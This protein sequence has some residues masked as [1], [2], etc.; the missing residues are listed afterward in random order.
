MKHLHHVFWAYDEVD[1]KGA[2]LA[3][4]EITVIDSQTEHEALENAKKTVIRKNYL[5]RQVRE[6]SSCPGQEES[7]ATQRY[8][9]ALVGKFM[10]DGH[11]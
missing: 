2:L 6:C 4:V 5:F 10:N 7:I 1:S 3:P 8:L 9:A 11:T